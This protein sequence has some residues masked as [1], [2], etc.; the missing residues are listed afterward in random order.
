[1][2]KLLLSLGLIG[3][4]SVSY[5]NAATVSVTVPATVMTNFPNITGSV[6]VTQVIVSA[7][8]TNYSTN[9]QFVNTYTNWTFFTNS[10][11]TN[12]SSYGTNYTWT[13][14]NY[15]G[16]TNTY[17]NSQPT[18]VDFSNSVA[19]STNAFP[20][21]LVGSV[22]SNGVA[23]TYTGMNTLFNNGLWVTNAGPGSATFT[24]NYQ[25]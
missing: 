8:A 20:V 2:K 15:Y 22:A 7:A 6:R 11:Y 9:F 19:A 3:A 10:A 5:L 25:Q 14:T 24:I 21:V 23:V 1:M 13:Y 4:L 16:V 18:L 17:T 12:I